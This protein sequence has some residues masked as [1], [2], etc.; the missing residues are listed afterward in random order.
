MN[1]DI[2]SFAR[3]GAELR[4]EQLGAEMKAIRRV[5]PDLNGRSPRSTPVAANGDAPQA[6]RGRRK[7]MSLAERKSVS[8]R[9]RKYWAARRKAGAAS[10]VV[11]GPDTASAPT[12]ASQTRAASVVSKGKTGRASKKRAARKGGAKRG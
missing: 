12:K 11:S 10:A 3:A 7:R 6:R 2:K 9:M 5:F 8:E 1:I 4:L